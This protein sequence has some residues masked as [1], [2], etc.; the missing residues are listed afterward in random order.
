MVFVLHFKCIDDFAR[1]AVAREV[2][3]SDKLKKKNW[4]GGMGEA[5]GEWQ[6]GFYE[7]QRWNMYYLDYLLNEL[8]Y[9]NSIACM[10]IL[11][12]MCLKI[13][14]YRVASYLMYIGK[15]RMEGRLKKEPLRKNFWVRQTYKV[16][17][18]NFKG[19]NI[20]YCINVLILFLLL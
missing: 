1:E 20:V 5:L 14:N 7:F 9:K 16:I 8:K 4:G 6:T 17:N 19:S 18:I 10:Y 12:T 13:N 2:V 15:L 3:Y 11:G